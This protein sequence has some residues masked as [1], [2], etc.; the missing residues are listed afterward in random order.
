MIDFNMEKMTI[1]RAVSELSDAWFGFFFEGEKKGAVWEVSLDKAVEESLRWQAYL[2]DAED[3][4]TTDWE[5]IQKLRLVR[6]CWTMIAKEMAERE[7]A[8]WADQQAQYRDGI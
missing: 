7:R 6:Y 8:D 2:T 3:D 1:E 5:I 4:V